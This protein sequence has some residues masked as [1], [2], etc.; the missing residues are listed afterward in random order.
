MFQDILVASVCWNRGLLTT[1]EG[2]G[3]HQLVVDTPPWRN[4]VLAAFTHNQ[5]TSIDSTIVSSAIETKL[6]YCGFSHMMLFIL[7]DQYMK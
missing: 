7:I 3:Q 6:P 2:D 5:L 1:V 4:I